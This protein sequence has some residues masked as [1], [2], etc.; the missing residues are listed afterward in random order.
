M[1]SKSFRDS[2]VL[3]IYDTQKYKSFPK[4]V[5]LMSNPFSKS[6]LN[7]GMNLTYTSE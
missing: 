7:D 3:P 2:T 6:D 5:S 4:L 1:L